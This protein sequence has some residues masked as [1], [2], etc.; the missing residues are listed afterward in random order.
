M[1]WRLIQSIQFAQKLSFIIHTT[2]YNA[3]DLYLV[4]VIELKDMHIHS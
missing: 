1:L 2:K 3:S 4:I